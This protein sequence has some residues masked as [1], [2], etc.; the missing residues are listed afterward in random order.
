MCYH[1]CK[2]RKVSGNILRE[3]EITLKTKKSKGYYPKPMRGIV[4]SV[5]VNGENTEMVFITNNMDWAASRVCSIILWD[6][7]E[8]NDQAITCFQF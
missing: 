5:E 1:L 4:A 8:R 3:D 6:S 7:M 2:K